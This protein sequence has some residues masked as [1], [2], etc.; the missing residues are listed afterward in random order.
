MSQTI[1]TWLDQYVPF[2][3]NCLPLESYLVGGTVRDILLGRKRDYLDLDFIIPQKA[4]EVAQHLAKTYQAGFVV[5]DR[6]RYIARVVFPQITCDFAQ[7][8]GETLEADLWRRDFTINAIAYCFREA[9]ISDPTGGL[10]DLK[11]QV[12]RMISARNLQDDP[13]RLLRGYRQAAQLNFTLE[14]T[15]QLTLKE[16]APELKKVAGER[17]KTELNYLLS[18]PLGSY[19]LEVAWQDKILESWLPNATAESVSLLAEIDHCAALI[20]SKFKVNISES[21]ALAK[22]TLLLSPSKAGAELL[23]LKASRLE[24]KL[25]INALQK[26]NLLKE[27]PSSLT[28]REQYFLFL[29]TQDS[30]VILT[31]LCLI[32]KIFPEEMMSLL[33]RYLN[34]EDPLAH[35]KPLVTG[36]DLQEYLGI[37]PSPLI[38]KLLTELQ[39]AYIEGKVHTVQESLTLAREI[40]EKNNP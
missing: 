27:N 5:L 1:A 3:L 2:D 16:L 7:Q 4:I 10:N 22:F 14:S 25:I 32:F 21:V 13:L 11:H 15:T 8:E 23:N 29:E 36:N 28:V 19:W 26:F 40:L 34:L 18:S 24:I 38:G 12:I 17:V 39:I 31:L 20:N 6:E 37:K 35:P 30:F 33:E 9:K